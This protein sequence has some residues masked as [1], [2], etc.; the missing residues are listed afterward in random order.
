MA[1]GSKIS[2]RFSIMLNSIETNPRK[3]GN[4]DTNESTGWL[5]EKCTGG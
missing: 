3:T 5:C 2:E 4:M 1:P